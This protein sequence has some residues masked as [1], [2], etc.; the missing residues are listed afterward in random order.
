MARLNYIDNETASPDQEKILAQLTQKSGKVANIWRI[1]A[2]SPM[3]LEAYMPF[4]KSLIKGTLD[5][6]FRELAYV[7]ASRINDCAYCANSHIKTGLR[8]GVTEQQ[9]AEIDNYTTST[10]FS[11]TEKSVLQFAEEVTRNV[12]ASDEVIAQLKKQLSEADIVELTLTVGLA[13]L[14]NRFNMALLVDPD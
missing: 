11:A 12:K 10:A 2:H 7:K 5:P 3:S 1:W 9:F 13:N 4:S 8:S 6:K 14:T